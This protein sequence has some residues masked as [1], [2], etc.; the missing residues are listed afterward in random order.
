MHCGNTTFVCHSEFSK[1]IKVE[2]ATEED[3]FLLSF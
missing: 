1:Y 3:V 2:G